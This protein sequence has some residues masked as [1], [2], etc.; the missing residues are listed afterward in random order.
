[1]VLEAQFEAG[2]PWWEVPFA[3]KPGNVSRAPPLVAP[4]QPRLDWQMWFAALGNYQVRACN[5]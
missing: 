2:G 4:H 5:A 1:M 3:Y